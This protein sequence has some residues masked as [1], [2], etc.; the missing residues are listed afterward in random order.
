MQRRQAAL[1]QCGLVPLPRKDLSRLEQELDQ[2]FSQVVILPQD[3][4][5]Q[6]EFTTAEKIRREWQASNETQPVTPS[7]DVDP[8]DPNGVTSDTP[9]PTRP[10]ESDSTSNAVVQNPLKVPLP[11]SP[12]T[13]QGPTTPISIY[14]IP[15]SFL[16]HDI[17]EEDDTPPET[18]KVRS[19]SPFNR[20]LTNSNL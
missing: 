19:L 9:R 5:E 7:G 16:F 18:E 15:G 6:G 17:P 1:Q 14:S 11:A 12:Q 13:A 4:P 8:E 2:K 20:C 3:Q 10:A